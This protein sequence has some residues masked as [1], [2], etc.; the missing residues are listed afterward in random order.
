MTHCFNQYECEVWFSLVKFSLFIGLTVWCY[1]LQTAR[2]YLKSSKPVML[3]G[4]SAILLLDNCL[5]QCISS[6][7]K[8]SWHPVPPIATAGCPITKQGMTLLSF[9]ESSLR[10]PA[11]ASMEEI[12]SQDRWLF[13]EIALG[14]R[15]CSVVLRGISSCQWLIWQQNWAYEIQNIRNNIVF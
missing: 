15:S 6:N 5:P 3:C 9:C 7:S 1:L 11:W 4:S 14:N 10:S 2:K 12:T 8:W 13:C